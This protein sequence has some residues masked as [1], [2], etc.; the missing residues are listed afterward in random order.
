LNLNFP[1]L[2][3][4][5]DSYKM[6]KLPFIPRI[7]KNS[8][9]YELN[10]TNTTLINDPLLNEDKVHTEQTGNDVKKYGRVKGNMM[11]LEDAW[12]IEIKPIVFNYAYI[13]A[14]NVLTYIKMK[15]TRI[16]DKYLKVRVKYSGEN[17]AV[18]QAIKST[19]TLSF[20]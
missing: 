12:D 11:Y 15:E 19:F 9:K 18:I 7:R 10:T 4:K 16:R 1:K 2:F 6:P 13:N 5:E 17:L 14:Q 20:A 3:N 8:G